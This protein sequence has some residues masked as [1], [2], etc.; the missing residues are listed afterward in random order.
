MITMTL[1][2]LWHG[3]AWGFLLWGL[4]HGLFLVINHAWR[5]LAGERL[6]YLIGLALTFFAVALAWVPFRAETL[7]ATLRFYMAMLG[8][9]APLINVS[10]EAIP[11]LL[12]AATIALL[13][14]TV[15]QVFAYDR[16]PPAT[17]LSFRWRPTFT[18][19]SAIGLAFVVSMASIVAV[20]RSSEFLYFKF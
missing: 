19:A 2:G 10:T 5:Y 4:L 13:L 8:G 6:P 3:A 18:W 12:I 1:G 17:I 9:E 16:D 11:I 7:E 15:E 20:G 14:P